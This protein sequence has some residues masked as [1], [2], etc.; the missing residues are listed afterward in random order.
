[1]EKGL[2]TDLHPLSRPSQI[3]FQNQRAKW[4]KQ[5]TGSL[6]ASQLL[7]EAGL[8]LATNLDMAV[9]S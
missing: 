9:S 7:S 5:K 2:A 4:R 8:A 3:W 1:M 6:G